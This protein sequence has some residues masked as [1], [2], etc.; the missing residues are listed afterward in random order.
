MWCPRPWLWH[1]ADGHG[2]VLPPAVTTG[3]S[4][5]GS[6]QSRGGRVPRQ[7]HRTPVRRGGGAYGVQ[8]IIGAADAH[9]EEC[10]EE[11]EVGG[12]DKVAPIGA[13]DVGD[14]EVVLGTDVCWVF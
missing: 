10:E 13:V 9:G 14:R 2:A 12:R 3:S 7:P 6:Q 1:G 11:V 4:R 5:A 8:G